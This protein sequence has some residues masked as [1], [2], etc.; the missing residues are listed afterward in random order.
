MDQH[1]YTIILRIM[2]VVYQGRI[3][4]REGF[5][6]YMPDLPCRI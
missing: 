5:S 2:P 4:L 3:L 1:L 6:I